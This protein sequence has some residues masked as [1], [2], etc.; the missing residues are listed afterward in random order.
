MS[1]KFLLLLLY[2]TS[3]ST[4]AQEHTYSPNVSTFTIHSP[5]LNTDRKIWVY[6][7]EGYKDSKH[8]YPVLYMHD[9]QNLFDKASSFSGE[10]RIDEQ[11][12]SLKAKTIVIGIEHG[13]DKRID[14]L[15]P[16]TNEKYGGGNADAY[17]DFIVSTLKPY[18]DTH[19]R[20]KPDKEDT[21]IF[22]SSVG[23]LVS[24]YAVLKY[25]K[26][27]GKAG[28]FSPSFWFSNDIYDLAI[29]TE[30]INARLYFMAGD[31]ESNEM[32][33][34]LDRM[35]DIVLTKANKKN[36]HK[37]IVHNG[38]HNETLWAKEFAEAYEWL[39]E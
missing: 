36:I 39:T 32:V 18:V 1:S 24:F 31:H 34:D 38:R 23:G 9:G 13:G 11:L 5:Q 10:W 29:K 30:H 25:P 16:Y 27:F 20:T 21:A 26:V 3:M 22:G 8:K 12:D 33:T 35:L 37:K 4:N 17:L 28:V 7:P 19:Y 2:L 6:L 14:E 15:T